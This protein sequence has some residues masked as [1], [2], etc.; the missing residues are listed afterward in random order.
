LAYANFNRGHTTHHCSKN[1][2]SS[3]WLWDIIKI[4]SNTA[5]RRTGTTKFRV[6]VSVIYYKVLWYLHKRQK[7]VS[8]TWWVLYILARIRG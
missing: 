7:H 8:F 6:Y 3:Q 4:S 2:F 1:T 5:G